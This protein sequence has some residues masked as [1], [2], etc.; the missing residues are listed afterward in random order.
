[1]KTAILCAALL[2]LAPSAAWRYVASTSQERYYVAP[3]R[4]DRDGGT[5]RTWEKQEPRDDTE[6]GKRR[7]DE[8][9][10]FLS[11][12]LPDQDARAYSH[13]TVNR[14]YDCPRGLA[15][16]LQY[17]YHREDGR[18]LYT[19]PARELQGWQSPPPDSIAERMMLDA[20]RRPAE[21]Y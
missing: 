3:E 13:S 2:L 21:E 18:V 10:A 20:C 6:D 11:S 9:V 8:L 4:T 5:V 16:F 14:E 1:M 15:R 7:R 12:K 19:T 17:H